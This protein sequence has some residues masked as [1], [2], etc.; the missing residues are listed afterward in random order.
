MKFQRLEIEARKGP[1][2]CRNRYQETKFETMRYEIIIVAATLGQ[3]M[4]SGLK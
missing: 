1:G 2:T 4:A 3:G